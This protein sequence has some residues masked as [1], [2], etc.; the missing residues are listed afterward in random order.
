[1]T[2]LSATRIQQKAVLS[3]VTGMFN[4]HIKAV[5]VPVDAAKLTFGAN[6]TINFGTA[7]VAT[8]TPCDDNGKVKT[9]SN[10]DDLV[11]WLKNAYTD[12]LT[13][14]LTIAD[15]ELITK[16]FVPPTD[17]LKDAT[18][19]KAIYVKL[20]A[21]LVDNLASATLEISRAVTAGWSAVDAH[22]ALQANYAELVA[23]KAAIQAASDYYAGRVTFYQS[24]IAP[25]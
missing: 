9:F 25:V 16:A 15:F 13:V 17:A 10:I 19:K 12:I 14:D 3:L 11:S 22:P 1:M 21:G 20:V 7:N 5:L 2:P 4:G 8:Y 6:V 23:K 24:I 18:S